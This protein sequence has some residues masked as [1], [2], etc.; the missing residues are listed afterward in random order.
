[1]ESHRHFMWSFKGLLQPALWVSQTHACSSWVINFWCLLCPLGMGAEM[2]G[3]VLWEGETK[4]S[5][6]SYLLKGAGAGSQQWELVGH[7]WKHWLVPCFYWAGFLPH[8]YWVLCVWLCAR[9]RASKGGERRQIG[10]LLLWLWLP[11]VTLWLLCQQGNTKSLPIEWLC[12]LIEE[13]VPVLSFSTLRLQVSAQ[14]LIP[15]LEGETAKQGC[16][17]Q[18]GMGPF[19]LLEWGG[20][21]SDAEHE[22]NNPK[23]TP[24]RVF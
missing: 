12:L 10:I 7:T 11:R 18:N 22:S 4:G 16:E 5:E 9:I 20:T 6:S 3:H 23:L 19:L 15:F 21:G 1:M 14:S 17:I 2:W 24:N 13:G 8:N